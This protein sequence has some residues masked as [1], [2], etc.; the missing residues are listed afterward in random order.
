MLEKLSKR[1][2]RRDQ[3]DGPEATRIKSI[4]SPLLSVSEDQLQSETYRLHFGVS[5]LPTALVASRFM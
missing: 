5:G 4:W 3:Q 2:L 1:Q